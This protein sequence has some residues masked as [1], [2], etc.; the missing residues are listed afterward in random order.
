MG[1]TPSRRPDWTTAAQLNSRPSC[2]HRQ[3]DRDHQRRGQRLLQQPRERPLGARHQGREAEE[4]VAGGVAGEA[5]LGEHQHL[6][7]LPLRLAREAQ[8]LRDVV[9]GVGHVDGRTGGAD[10]Q[11]AEGGRRHEPS[12]TPKRGRPGQPWPRAAISRSPRFDLRSAARQ[13]MI[14]LGSGTTSVPTSTAEVAVP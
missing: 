5:Q 1:T 12:I 14:A 2:A 7:A 4:Q 10:A 8:D 3:A 11:E 13:A 9:L 6:H